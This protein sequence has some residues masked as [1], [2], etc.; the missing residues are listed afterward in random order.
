MQ[1]PDIALTD[2]VSALGLLTRLPV[3]VDTVRAAER[4]ARAAWAYPLAGFAVAALQAAVAT[5]LMWLDVPV[6]LVA[7][8][9]VLAGIVLT[10]AMHEDGLADSA[11]GIW[12]G[13]TSDRRLEIM[14][15]SRIGTYGVLA[16]ILSLMLRW[17][18]LS[19]LLYY[20]P[21]TLALFPAAMLSRAAMVT[22]M[23]AL[24]NA[25]TDGLARSVGRPDEKTALIAAFIA[26]AGSVVVLGAWL[27]PVLL[28]LVLA[29]LTCAS[30][31]MRKIGGQ[32][33]DILGAT[34]QVCEIAV[35]V[36]LVALAI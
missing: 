16:L 5:F 24:P 13:W 2:I 9:V 31:P 36:T 25:R 17:S 21:V 34:H 3:R 14:K 4:G 28:V 12:G 22:V 33:G 30:I 7:G 6:T 27:I 29:A 20:E 10:G 35:L 11:D 8:L 1:K 18:A 19:T 32:T 15:D 26:V 23:S